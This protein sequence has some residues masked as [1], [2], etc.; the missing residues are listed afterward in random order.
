MHCLSLLRQGIRPFLP[1][2]LLSASLLHAVAQPEDSTPPQLNITL[3][4]LALNRDAATYTYWSAGQIKEFPLP[5]DAVS[6]AFDYTGPSPMLVF[7]GRPNPELDLEAQAIGKI[8]LTETMRDIV[9]ICTTAAGSFNYL[10]LRQDTLPL[11]SF[12]FI[13][14]TTDPVGGLLDQERLVIQPGQVSVVT[15]DNF[16]EKR[17]P[18][19]MASQVDNQWEMFYSSS[20]SVPGNKRVFIIV[21][22]DSDSGKLNIRGANLR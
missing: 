14:T 11:G 20:W 5:Y 9:L 2:L 3:R 16:S 8:T 4:T 15:E 17:V 22:N 18:I 13:N 19:R 10:P 21:Y 12:C 1:L 6:Q 7:R